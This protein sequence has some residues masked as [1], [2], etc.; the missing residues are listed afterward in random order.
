ML[1]IV[2]P[3]ILSQIRLAS[4]TNKSVPQSPS[5]SKKLAFLESI[6]KNLRGKLSNLSTF[7]CVDICKACTFVSKSDGVSL[8]LI[9]PNI[10]VEM[11]VA[12]PF[13]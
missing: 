3:D 1:L 11:K 10:E 9:V 6:K 8:R 2:C 5:I 13:V 12:S 7:C 4:Q